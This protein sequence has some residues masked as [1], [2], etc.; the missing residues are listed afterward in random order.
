MP[1]LDRARLDAADLRVVTQIPTRYDDLDSLGHVNNA[2]AAVILQE[3]RVAFHAAVGFVSLP[4]GLHSIVAALSIEYAG[5]MHF[6]EPVEVRS[7]I[8]QLG[9]TSYV[10]GQVA[11]QGGRPALYAESVMV[12]TD[13]NGPAPIPDAMRAAYEAHLVPG[14]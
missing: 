5:E 8:L 1:R 3:A 10:I 2:A 9:R 7:G 12:L 11:Y 6:P 4:G 13:A 14:A